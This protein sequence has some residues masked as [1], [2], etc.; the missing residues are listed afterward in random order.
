MTGNSKTSFGRPDNR[1]DHKKEDFGAP[2]VRYLMQN[3][4]VDP[5]SK[6]CV[7]HLGSHR[8]DNTLC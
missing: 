2:T 4:Y 5:A 3:K 6:R 7:S 8:F 1:P